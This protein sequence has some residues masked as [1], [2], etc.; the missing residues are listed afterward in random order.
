[1]GSIAE[2]ALR[3]RC[4]YCGLPAGEPC[5]DMRHNDRCMKAR[6]HQ[7]RLNDA[8]CL[9]LIPVT[10]EYVISY[11][12]QEQERHAGVARRR[13]RTDSPDPGARCTD[14]VS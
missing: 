10:G 4:G 8:R 7:E 9:V 11:E 12:R 2:L 3:I 6:P 13:G 14:G 5:Q 1:M